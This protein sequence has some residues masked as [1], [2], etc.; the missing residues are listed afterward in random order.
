MVGP[1]KDGS[2]ITTKAF[3]D[4]LGVKV[5]F[6][7]KLSK[8]DWCRLAID[9]DIFINT[10]HFDNMPVSVMEAMALGL[11]LVSTNVGGIPYLVSNNENAILVNDNDVEQMTTSI[12]DLISDKEKAF[13]MSQNGRRLIE[14]IDW[15]IVKQKW[16][17]LLK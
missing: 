17:S 9:N 12:L 16:F 15:D 5:N 14:Q 13:N 7:G 8:E 4:Q 3:A 10:T 11:P 6:T 1:D 2:L